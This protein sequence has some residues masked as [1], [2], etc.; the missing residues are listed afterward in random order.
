MFQRGGG[1]RALL[2]L[3]FVGKKLRKGRGI[4]PAYT[5][6]CFVRSHARSLFPS[7]EEERNRGQQSQLAVATEFECDPGGG[8]REGIEEG[9]R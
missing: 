1:A 5:V 8:E 3:L 4:A 2:Q 7:E 6:P 9:S